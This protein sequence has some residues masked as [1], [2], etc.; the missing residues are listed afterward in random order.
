MFRSLCWKTKQKHWEKTSFFF[1]VISDSGFSHL[2]VFKA[3]SV[4][5]FFDVFIGLFPES[6][7]ISQPL[8]Y[9]PGMSYAF[10]RWRVSYMS[11]FEDVIGLYFP[12]RFSKE[13]LA[14]LCSMWLCSFDF[15]NCHDARWIAL[16]NLCW[17]INVWVCVRMAW[18]V[19][20]K[21]TA[22][23]WPTLVGLYLHWM[24]GSRPQEGARVS[25][26]YLKPDVLLLFR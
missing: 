20:R 5:G 23:V 6:Q 25:R 24:C 26:K 14:K 9:F 7:W 13:N 3:S 19:L 12:S 8:D 11:T 18:R 1:A 4:F 17:I 22:N 21:Y 10:L 15:L 2:N 16:L